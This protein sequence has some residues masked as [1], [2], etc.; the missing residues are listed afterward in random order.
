[1]PQYDLLYRLVNL[2]R[3]VRVYS[4]VFVVLYTLHYNTYL[5]NL[6]IT[7][8]HIRKDI[9]STYSYRSSSDTKERH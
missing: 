9:P 7:E 1:M 4:N 5:L 3:V 6:K 8:E 2:R